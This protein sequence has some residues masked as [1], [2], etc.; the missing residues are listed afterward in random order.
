MLHIFLCNLVTLLLI[1]KFSRKLFYLI[2]GPLAVRRG[3]TS[4]VT[5]LVST[6]MPLKMMD[7]PSASVMCLYI[8]PQEPVIDDV[9]MDGALI[10][11]V[12]GSLSDF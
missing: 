9:R 12:C 1:W 10:T 5:S 8:V 7:A 3:F 4:H 6:G 2:A 11:M